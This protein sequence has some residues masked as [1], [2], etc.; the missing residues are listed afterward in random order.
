LFLRGS[1]TALMQTSQHLE[2]LFAQPF[3]AAIERMT[4]Q[5]KLGL[6]QPAM[7]GFGINAQTPRRLG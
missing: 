4:W 3:F 6:R 5:G 1:Q 2:V 7:Q